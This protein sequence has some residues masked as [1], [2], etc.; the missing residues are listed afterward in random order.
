MEEHGRQPRPLPHATEGNGA[1]PVAAHVP[2]DAQTQE[3]LEV[4]RALAA[5]KGTLGLLSRAL[6]Q[7]TVKRKADE[8]ER[9]DRHGLLVRPSHW[10]E[11]T[12]AV[13]RNVFDLEPE[14]VAY[15]K[16]Q[17][18][19]AMVELAELLQELPWKA[20]RDGTPGREATPAELA[21][22]RKELVDVLIFVGNVAVALGFDDDTVWQ[23]V[24]A[25]AVRNRGRRQ[26]LGKDY[27]PQEKAPP[28]PPQCE[29]DHPHPSHPCGR[30]VAPGQPAICYLAGCYE[31]APHRHELGRLIYMEQ[32]P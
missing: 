11:D 16:E 15:V 6:L 7:A 28:Q 30:K 31:T 19:A 29:F 10:L 26:G 17:V 22:A 3:A 13:Q 27:W 9:Q 5:D 20:A 21:K 24:N 8:A 23:E 4:A 1:P 25:L 14:G 2:A 32:A 18:T 12:C